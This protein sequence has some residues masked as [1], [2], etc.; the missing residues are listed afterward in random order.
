VPVLV[1]DVTE[2]EADKILATLDPL[3]AMAEANAE[4]LDELLRGIDTGCQEL[5]DMMTALAEE[6]GLYAVAEAG[7]PVLA[8]GDKS[9]FQQMTFTLHD[10]QAA[11]VRSAMEKAKAAG[12]DVSECN[13]NGNGNALAFI[14]GAF[15]D[16]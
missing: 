9:E 12:G 14:A 7:P 16:G 8:S 11:A 3:A 15:C 10:S 13:E 4:K 5:A 2:A 6:N 1:L